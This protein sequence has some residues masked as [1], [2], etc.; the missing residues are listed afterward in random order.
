MLSSSPAPL[1]SDM[2]KFMHFCHFLWPLKALEK[3][4]PCL[5]INYARLGSRGQSHH[6]FCHF[7][8]MEKEKGKEHTK[9]EQEANNGGFSNIGRDDKLLPP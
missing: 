3:S 1:F 9:E 6:V 2:Y 5:E 4:W 7:E 8:I